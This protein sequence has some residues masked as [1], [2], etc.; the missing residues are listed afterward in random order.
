MLHHSIPHPAFSLAKG[1]PMRGGV[2]SFIIIAVVVALRV[3]GSVESWE[4]IDEETINL[5][6][7]Q[8][9]TLQY[10]LPRSINVRV[11]AN[12]TN[13]QPMMAYWVSPADHETIQTSEDLEALFERVIASQC[14][15]SGEN[16]VSAELRLPTGTVYVYLES[17]GEGD[18][19]IKYKVE[20]FQ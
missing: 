1:N 11:T 15:F 8:A 7:D 3:A 13:G 17:L 16:Q 19:T 5:T 2:I 18:A 20:A 14:F 10:E 6:N 12:E 4:T 9:Y